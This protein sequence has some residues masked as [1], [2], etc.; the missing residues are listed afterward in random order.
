MAAQRRRIRGKLFGDEGH[1]PICLFTLERSQIRTIDTLGLVLES[2]YGSRRGGGSRGQGAGGLYIAWKSSASKFST[3][4]IGQGEYGTMIKKKL[5][6]SPGYQRG[7]SLSPQLAA[8][9]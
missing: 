7:S 2:K 1:N 6:Y 8:A 3:R 5:L 9:F 4:A